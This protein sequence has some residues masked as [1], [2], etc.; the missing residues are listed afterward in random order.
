MTLSWWSARLVPSWL[1]IGEHRV[2]ERVR[3]WLVHLCEAGPKISAAVQIASLTP[4]SVTRLTLRTNSVGRPL[5]LAAAPP[6]AAAR[7]TSFQAQRPQYHGQQVG[8]SRTSG[9]ATGTSSASCWGPSATALAG[10]YYHLWLGIPVPAG[11]G[12]SAP[13]DFAGRGH[14][15]LG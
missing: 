5:V 2:L 4:S 11:C 6:A 15:V 14:G 13:V 8:S 10:H 1:H 3:V 12:H 9:V 7:R